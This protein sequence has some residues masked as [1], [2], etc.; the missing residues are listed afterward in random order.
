MTFTKGYIPWNK[1]KKLS[2]KTR[3]RMSSSRQGLKRKP[4]TIEKMK[5]GWFPKGHLATGWKYKKHHSIE[6]KKTMSIAHIGRFTG[7]NSPCWIKDRT[8]LKKD[9]RRNDSAYGEWR[10]DVWQRDGYKCKMSNE[11]CV[12]KIEAHHILGWSKHPELRYQTNNGITL[13][14]AHHPRKR[15][16]EKRL[17]PIFQELV[18]V[19]KV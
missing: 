17:V 6:S 14:H 12:G 2:V 8:K 5:K 19:S 15:A 4:E 18:S 7:K 3:W 10:N 9:N 16:E 11:T 1:G 13:C